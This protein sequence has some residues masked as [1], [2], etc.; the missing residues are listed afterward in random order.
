MTRVEVMT[1]A[2]AAFWL[3]MVVAISFLE[4]PLKF[5]AP[6]VTIQV[7]LAIGR[8]V[9]R[10]LNLAECVLAMALVA[11]MVVGHGPADVA[12]A[13][14]VASACLAIQMAV[15]RPVMG[16]R[17]DAIR[18]GATYHGRSRAHIAYVAAEGVKAAAL[19]AVVLA[20]LVV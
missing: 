19:I 6:G 15:I 18:D 4:A 20:A 13:G 2:L 1:T 16:R 9:F 11:L 7:G 5:R 8:V 14:L 3:G 12:A 10:A 17:T